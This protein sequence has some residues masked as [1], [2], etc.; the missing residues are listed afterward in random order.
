M[1]LSIKYLKEKKF[2]AKCRDHKIII[3]QPKS[4]NGSDQGMD[5]IELFNAAL[6]SCAAFYALRFLSRRIK[7]LKGLEVE[8]QWS[9]AENPHRI[10]EIS[11]S[12]KLPRSILGSERKGLL[13][14]VEY[15][16]VMNTLEHPPKINVRLNS[17][18]D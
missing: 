3:D 5:P 2:E 8:S 14:S 6:A 12:V 16:T 15:C 4:R 13:K 17:V 11:L 10:G 7:D 1:N 9:F 18:S